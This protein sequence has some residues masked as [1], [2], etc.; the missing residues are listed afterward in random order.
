MRKTIMIISGIALSLCFA[1]PAFANC[2]FYD[3]HGDHSWVLGE[4]NEPSCDT[5]GGYSE[6][7]DYCG[8]YNYVSLPA[9]QHDWNWI[10]VEPASCTEEGLGAAECSNCGMRNY[11]PIQPPGHEWYLVGTIR[12]ATCTQSEIIQEKCTYCGLT[13]EEYG[14]T[15]SHVYGGWNITRDAT[16]HSEGVKTR[17]C[18]QCGNTLTDYFYPDGT[19]YRGGDNNTT[20]VK[21]VQQI[22]VDL[23]YLNDTVDGS[24]GKN[25]EAAVKAFQ[26]AHSLTADGIG[27]P[28]T[29]QAIRKAANEKTIDF[30]K[31]Q[32]VYSLSQLRIITKQQD[33]LCA[34]AYLGNYEAEYADLPKYLEVAD[35]SYKFPFLTEIPKECYLTHEGK[36]LY[37]I[38][39]TDERAS[40]TVS[41][42]KAAS[43]NNSNAGT[44][45]TTGTAGSEG[46]VGTAGT[47][48]QVIYRS[49]SGD[50][51][52]VQ[53]NS[54]EKMPNLQIVIV[55]STGKSVEYYPFM[56]QEDNKLELPNGGGVLDFTPYG[57]KILTGYMG[58]LNST[59]TKQS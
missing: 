24:F 5:E 58:D 57:S 31:D 17:R 30:Y 6:F 2:D 18:T 16:D 54:N 46:T 37:C 41:T 45:G 34:V 19:I 35:I 36:Q 25:T 44:A 1:V 11:E 43:E 22:L 14:E 33:E 8:T 39:P 4:W 55:D 40:V 47:V 51:F 49:T 12:E 42:W 38:V 52:Y 23:K 26:S 9:T 48:G 21:E 7:C 59:E 3:T 28:Q 27:W 53:G 50:P 15:G 29:I 56:N 32:T 20:L 10:V 13:R